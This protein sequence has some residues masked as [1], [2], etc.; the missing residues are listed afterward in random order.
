MRLSKFRAAVDTFEAA[1]DMIAR[2]RYPI[3]VRRR[4]DFAL[5]R[6]AV[7]GRA[8]IECQVPSNPGKAGAH[9]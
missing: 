5:W 6:D 7:K 1:E 4:L 9:L 3:L 2:L 8:K